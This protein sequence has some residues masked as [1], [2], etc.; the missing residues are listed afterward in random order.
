MF[1][2]GL[3]LVKNQFT[4]WGNVFISIYF[5]GPAIA[6]APPRAKMANPLVIELFFVCREPSY[7]FYLPIGNNI[8]RTVAAL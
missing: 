8:Y 7:R 3:P 1:G 4:N 6:N 5:I 2:A